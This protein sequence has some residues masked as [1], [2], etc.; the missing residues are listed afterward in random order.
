MLHQRKADSSIVT[1]ISPQE[2]AWRWHPSGKPLRVLTSLMT[3]GS[4]FSGMV[5]QW[6][7]TLCQN[8]RPEV[9]DLNSLLK[10]SVSATGINAVIVVN[11]FSA[12]ILDFPRFVLMIRE[13]SPAPELTEMIVL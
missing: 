10:L 8:A 13:H 1:A 5:S 11:A 12:Q 7:N 4:S 9:A 6:S 2:L 3:L